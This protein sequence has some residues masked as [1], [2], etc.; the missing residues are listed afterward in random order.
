MSGNSDF[1]HIGEEEG[2]DGAKV[3]TVV[4]TPGS[5]S[6]VTL[7]GNH[8]PLSR[9]LPAPSHLQ[10]ELAVVAEPPVRPGDRRVPV[11]CSCAVV[12]QPQKL[13]QRL[14][15]AGKITS[16][17]GEK[18]ISLPPRPS[19]PFVSLGCLTVAPQ[20]PFLCCLSVSPAQ[21]P[22]DRPGLYS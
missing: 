3:T 15:R 11:S 1:R 20:Q 13:P 10:F 19:K 5:C 14:H 21:S 8:P 7:C 4:D 6:G 12:M 9:P 22:P 16:V 17:F 2:G 18:D